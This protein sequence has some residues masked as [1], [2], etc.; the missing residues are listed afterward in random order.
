MSIEITNWLRGL[1]LEQY[2]S[3]FHDNAIDTEV[4]RELTADDLKDLGVNLVG[5]RRK[6]LAAIA[7]LGP[8]LPKSGTP[9]ASSGPVR[10]GQDAGIAT[11]DAERR[12]LTVMFCDLVGSTALSTRL[13]PEDLREVI[14]AYHRAVTEIITEFDGFVSRYMGDG[15]LVYFGYPQAHEDDAERA[16]RAGLSAIAAIGRL[17]VRSVKLQARV[18][19]AT[20]LV[21]V[22]D[23]IGAV[24]A[25]LIGAGSA[26]EQ[27][28][29]G[30]TPN[31]AA[32]LQAL[33]EPGTVVIAAGT[34]RLVGDLFEYRDL[35]AVEVKGIAAPVPVW[36]VLLPS[37]IANRF[38]ALRG[39]TLTRLVGRDEEIDLLLRRWAR[40][41]A[42]DGQVVLISGEPGIGKSRTVAALAE[43]LRGEP[44]IRLRYFCSPYHRD[45]A[46]FPFV[47]QLGRASRFA[48]DD[49][50]GAK[51]EKLEAVLAGAAPPEED[52]TLLADLLSLPASELRRPLPNLSPQRKKERT[53]EALIRQLEGLAHQQP[54]MMVFEDVHWIDPTSRELLDLTVERMRTLPVLLIVTFRPEFQPP[55][56]GQP[57]VTMLALNRLDRRDRSALVAQITG[58]RALPEEVI[59]QIVDRTDGVPLF[60]EELTKSVLE[61][62]VLHEEAD[63]Y[64]LD[65]ALPS[66]AIP[67]TL[68]ASLLARLDRLAPV[69][70]VAQIGAAIGRQFPF[71][72]LR[73]VSRLPEDELQTSLARLVASGLIL[74]RGT[75]PDAVY[76]FKH[77][78]VQDAAHDSLLRSA[79]QQLHARIAAALEAHSPELMDSQPELFAQH[80]AEAELV[81]KSVACWGKAGR[82]SATRS[83]MAEAATQFQRGLDQLTLLP[84][85]P[86]RQRQELEFW[87]A[88]GGVF[89]AV[90]GFAAPEAAQANARSRELWERLGS[91]SDFL[92]VPYRQSRYHMYRGELDLAQRLNEDLMRLS[93]QR[94]DSAGL[95]LGHAS[96]GGN[97][98]FAGKFASSRW[99]LEEVLALHDSIAHGSLVHQVGFHP[100]VNSQAYL[101]I[102]LFCLGFPD[103]ALAR[104]RAAI[105]EAGRLA[106][107]PSLAGSLAVGVRLLSLVG[108]DVVLRELAKQ[109]VA[110][111]TEQGFSFWRA[112]GAIF[113]G[114]VDVKNGDVT[115]GVSLLRSG[116]TAYRG[117]GAELAMPYYT[118]LL[119]GACEIA[120][121]IEEGLTL[122][123]EALQIV[124]RTREC[125]FAAELNRR[126][127]QLLLRQGDSKA[128]EEFYRKALS[129]AEEQGAR[130]W[131]LR[132]VVSLATLRRDQGR[133]VEARDLLAPVYGWFTE[134]FDTPD[135][136]EAKALLGELGGA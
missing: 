58:G 101:G 134:G 136:K 74:Q 98:S 133:H 91:P 120:G 127:G 2:A 35:G 115:R 62:G 130:L 126:K 45:S 64:V 50:P 76:A 122:F 30:E 135:L 57:Q 41:K 102:V 33:A 21:V 90:K 89:F 3:A 131:E 99:H 63:R 113:R 75:P 16:V 87:S 117:T 68:H 105:A 121:Q 82:R 8:D 119:A 38:E 40:A 118:A 69:R 44:H 37:N 28:V 48:R 81:E 73:T 111:A 70:L 67:T 72:V 5:H 24:V 97:L 15:V 79:R 94:N 100:H 95:V 54:V 4:L 34:R 10:P 12:Q 14:G 116:S 52:L 56:T 128:A 61:S 106:H 77:V 17:N 71:A 18:G 104:I 36:Q 25:D 96:S 132:A 78:L 53:L 29:V 59:E 6:L 112:L 125:W 32:R 31:L 114:W 22:G 109:L 27:S 19:I 49:S 110:V 7:A 129:I 60:V 9:P 65:R 92:A 123:E 26:Q 1:G 124:E 43:R 11:G 107:P 47:D 13:D 23:L 46:L 80:Y 86:E 83:A 93:R 51:L 103:Q 108:D 20:G 85:S 66:F 84:D 39:S 42:G 88:L 55:W